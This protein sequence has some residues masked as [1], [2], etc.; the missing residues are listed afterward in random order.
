M[1]VTA[2]LSPAGG[3]PT[4]ERAG[5]IGTRCFGAQVDDQ[6][7]PTSNFVELQNR[8]EFTTAR[9]VAYPSFSLIAI[10]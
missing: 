2:Y 7:V 1:I 4:R 9:I 6:P 3:Y 5:L 8:H 10:I